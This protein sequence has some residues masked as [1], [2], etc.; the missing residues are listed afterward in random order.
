MNNHLPQREARRREIDSRG[1]PRPEQLEVGSAPV[2]LSPTRAQQ[3][4]W[5]C[6]M[7]YFFPPHGCSQLP[8]AIWEAH[9]A[10]CTATKKM[11]CL[12]RLG[13]VWVS[14]RTEVWYVVEAF[15]KQDGRINGL[16]FITTGH[17][18][19]WQKQAWIKQL[20]CGFRVFLACAGSSQMGLVLMEHT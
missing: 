11:L 1:G 15:L 9:T 2:A 10:L 18:Q 17:F 5:S 7:H 19:W 4:M 12:P 8:S 14:P 6:R 20:D 16:F 3:K 13:C